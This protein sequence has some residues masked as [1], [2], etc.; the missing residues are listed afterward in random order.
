MGIRLLYHWIPR[1]LSYTEENY[2]KAI[3]HLADGGNK[4]VLTNEIAEL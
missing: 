1:M 2:I 3:Y 4:A